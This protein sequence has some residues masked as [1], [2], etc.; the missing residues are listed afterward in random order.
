[1]RRL[2]RVPGIGPLSVH[3]IIAAVGDGGQFVSARDLAAWAEL[4]EGSAGA[5]GGRPAKEM[6][7][8][9]EDYRAANAKA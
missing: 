8:S 1:M 7:R 2:M 6:L 5:A 4:A 3:A 9:G